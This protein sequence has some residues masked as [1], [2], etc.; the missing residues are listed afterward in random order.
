MALR[1]FVHTL[2]WAFRLE[3]LRLPPEV[4]SAQGPGCVETLAPAHETSVDWL[5]GG[6]G[7]QEPLHKNGSFPRGNLVTWDHSSSYNAAAC[8][9]SELCGGRHP[10]FLLA[11]SKRR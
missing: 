9:G 8:L 4:L 6:Q 5:A 2:H 7:R 10:A 11:S 1:L 3:S